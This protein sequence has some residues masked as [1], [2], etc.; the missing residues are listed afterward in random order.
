MGL[1]KLL[2]FVDTR[3][4]LEMESRTLDICQNWPA[5]SGSLQMEHFSSPKLT[6][7][8][9]DDQSGHKQLFQFDRNEESICRM[10]DPISQL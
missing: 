10:A 9:K 7:L 5:G 4:H 2:H 3:E 8:W 1:L 6:L